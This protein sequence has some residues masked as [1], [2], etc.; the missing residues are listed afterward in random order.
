MPTN[1]TYVS[2]LVRSDSNPVGPEQR[3]Q[4]LK[5]LLAANL[6][7]ILFADAFFMKR[8]KPED[9]GATVK[10]VPLE[11]VD[12]D[13]VK[14]CVGANPALPPQRTLNKDTLCYMALMNAKPELLVRAKPW[15]TTP[16]VAYIDS[17]IAKICDSANTLAELA[18]ISFC[19]IPLVMLP[20]CHPM[21]PKDMSTL[22]H[23]IDWT[24]CGGF[25]VVP[26][27]RIDA[28]AALHR[29]ALDAFLEQGLLTWEVN[30]WTSWM[31]GRE[32]VVWYAADHNDTML[33]AIPPA[34]KFNATEA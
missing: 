25:F 13:T 30:V 10:L 7:L 5:P 1:T 9:L 31:P 28:F 22:A 12:L 32:D 34:K 17:G 24:F 27:T 16:Y 8:I 26:T 6:P 21:R 11:F 18:R 4:W 23:H 3:L 14:A 33:R 20:G 29:A 15:I 2:V 19:D